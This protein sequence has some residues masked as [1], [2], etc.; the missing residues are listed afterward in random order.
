LSDS[1]LQTDYIGATSKGFDEMVDNIYS[2]WTKLDTVAGK[3]V[4]NAVEHA[5]RYRPQL[6]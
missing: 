1:T 2:N 6:R 5:F 3:V 4:T